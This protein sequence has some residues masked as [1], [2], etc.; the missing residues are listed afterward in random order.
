M[1]RNAFSHLFVHVS[2]LAAARTF[3]VDRLGLEVLVEEPGYLQVGGGEGF[4][5]GLEEGPPAEVG[6]VGIEI[7]VRVGDVDV[8]A[9]ALRDA[10]LEITDPA[11]QAWGARH[12]WTHDPDGY[13]ISIYS[14]RGGDR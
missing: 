8:T 4:H 3:Y 12:A 9:S 2:S 10:G 14:T 6:A 13:R 11:D 5:I 1:G 7:V